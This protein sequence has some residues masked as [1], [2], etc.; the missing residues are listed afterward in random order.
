MTIAAVFVFAETTSGMTEASAIRSPARRAADEVAER[1]VAL[2]AVAGQRLGA[3][4]V[5]ERARGD[6]V[7]DDL[8]PAD[9][10]RDVGLLA[11][12]GGIDERL[13]GRVGGAQAQRAAARRAHEPDGDRPRA[14]GHRERRQVERHVDAHE[15]Q[16]GPA[17]RRVAAHEHRRLG[18]VVGGRRDRLRGLPDSRRPRTARRCGRR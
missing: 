15:V 8:D 14:L 12:V 18:H 1:G 6:E 10:R 2:H 3:A 4:P 11:Q 13:V 17:Q 16:V 5:V 9:H 7:A